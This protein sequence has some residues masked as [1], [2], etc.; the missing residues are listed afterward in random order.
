M[1]K[2]REGVLNFWN[3]LLPERYNLIERWFEVWRVLLYIGIIVF[4]L[5]FAFVSVRYWMK[6]TKPYTRT[7]AIWVIAMQAIMYFLLL[8]ITLVLLDASV[9]FEPRILMPIY[10]MLLLLIVALLHWLWNRPRKIFKFMAVFI[11]FAL[12]LSFVEDTMDTVKSLR[13]QG[14]GFANESWTESQTIAEINKYPDFIIYTNR[15]RAINLF[16]NRGAYILPSQLNPSTGEPWQNYQKDVDAIRKS[17]FDGKAILVVFD[18]QN[19][20]ADSEG[21][22]WM[23]DLTTGLP[24]F[25]EYP[26]GMIF[27]VKE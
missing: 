16:L 20:I 25:S 23:E 13:S 7:H 11:V 4:I 1:E 17:V 10:N 6:K 5:G 14:Q 18:Y 22:E 15:P 27:G 24:V 26:D 8:V 21:Q 2:A 19:V 3:W 9:N 12:M